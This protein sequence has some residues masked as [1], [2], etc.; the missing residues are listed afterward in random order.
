ME[1]CKRYPGGM[2][3]EHIP[4]GRPFNRIMGPLTI[5]QPEQD[6]GDGCGRTWCR[7]AERPQQAGWQVPGKSRAGVPCPNGLWREFVQRICKI[8]RY[9]VELRSI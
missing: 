9:S 2:P 8:G 1:A 6:A 5:G 3:F 4:I 7:D